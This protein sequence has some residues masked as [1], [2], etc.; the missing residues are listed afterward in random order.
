MEI[1]NKDL[2]KLMHSALTCTSHRLSPDAD[3]EALVK[4]LYSQG[5]TAL[6][7][8]GAVLCGE[9]LQNPVM[10]ALADEYCAQLIIS[11][12]QL[13]ELERLQKAFEE[14]NIDYMPLK[15]CVLK[16]L[17][18]S[19]ELRAM[20]DADVL[21]RVEQYDRIKAVMERLGYKQTFNSDHE[22]VWE[23]GYVMT[24]LHKRLV[25]SY[26]E[27]FYGYYGDGW[28]LAKLQKG[29]RY[30]LSPED[31]YVHLVT[32]LAKHYRDGGIGIR[33]MLDLWVWEK[34]NPKLDR[35]YVEQQLEQ[36]G[37]LEFFR[38]VE[39]T[40]KVWFEDET[41]DELTEKVTDR[42]FGSG[43]WGS[44]QA[45]QLAGV[46]RQAA[47]SGSTAAGKWEILIRKIFPNRKT[48]DENWP[49]LEK[50]V[51]AVAWIKRWGYLLKNKKGNWH[52]GVRRTLEISD[53]DVEQYRRDLQSVGL[54]FPDK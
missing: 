42:I 25:P 2:L 40:L 18:P 47:K 19:H 5:V 23:K 45:Q 14:E 9:D 22:Y 1:L 53:R 49:W 7:Y 20:S 36:L 4:L 29:H 35:D 38:N 46:T 24:E 51:L 17:Y 13:A 54:E 48:M 32:H 12:T 44:K 33:Q 30:A 26:N 11:E 21:I 52:K 31:T 28:Q 41:G 34:A 16:K 3:R 8:Q 10:Q 43:L 39:K 27:D 6:G 15:G 50:D 37:L